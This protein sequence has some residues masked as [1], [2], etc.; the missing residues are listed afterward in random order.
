MNKKFYY[1]IIFL[2]IINC[3]LDTKTGI[4]SQSKDLVSENKNNKKEKLFKKSEIY[5]KEFN[6][7]LKIRL[8]ENLEKKILDKNLS[9][10]TGIVKFNGELKKLSKYKFPKIDKF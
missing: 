5:E 3:S 4:W 10:N 7:D 2:F 1:F 9:N 6:K 8:K